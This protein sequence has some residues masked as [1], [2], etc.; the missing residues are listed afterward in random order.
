MNL[1]D[2]FS[3]WLSRVMNLPLERLLPFV[4]VGAKLI[5]VLIVFLL[6]SIVTRVITSLIRSST[7]R[8]LSSGRHKLGDPR[9]IQTGSTILISLMKYLVFF[10]AAMISLEILGINPT[11]LL[12]GAGFAGL[13]IGFGAQALI[14]DIISGFFLMFE[15]QYA[16]GDYVK[17]EGCEGIV[18]EIQLRITKIR[19]F[20]GELHIIPNG[21]INKVTNYRSDGLRIWIAVTIDVKEDIEKAITVLQAALDA[22]KQDYAALGLLDGPNVLGVEEVNELGS[23]IR[24]WARGVPMKHWN[25]A[26]EINKLIKST[27][28][29]NGIRLASPHR[30]VTIETR[31]AISREEGKANG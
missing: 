12:A 22:A 3:S 19:D 21:N 30:N 25:I 23:R 1:T 16:V 8:R 20:G 28:D 29:E 31:A 15:D 24:I 10:I 9:R 14:K 27:L 17:V 5:S 13:T 4:Q 11:S 2:R 18:E 7:K 26:R 6:A